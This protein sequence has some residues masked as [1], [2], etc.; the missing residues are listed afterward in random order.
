MK[1]LHVLAAALL[2]LPAVSFAMNKCVGNDGRITYQE[3]FCPDL[4]KKHTPQGPPGADAGT[5]DGVWKRQY[6][7]LQ[8][9]EVDEFRKYLS[10]PGRDKM[11]RMD[12]KG[13]EKQLAMARDLTPKEARFVDMRIH[14]GGNRATIQAQGMG[15]NVMTGG[16]MEILG[17]IEMVKEGGGWKVASESWRPAG[18]IETR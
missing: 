11:D 4:T 10:K 16:K 3:D 17:T 9:G 6:G 14:P 2:C 7:A 13:R 12:E 5:P 1:S 15:R 8:D 18:R